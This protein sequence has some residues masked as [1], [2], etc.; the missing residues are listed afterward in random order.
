MNSMSWQELHFCSSFQVNLKA[1]LYFYQ[2]LFSFLGSFKVPHGGFKAFG[3]EI[4]KAY[5]DL[6][7]LPVAHTCFNSV[8][9]P[10]YPNKEILKDKLLKAILEGNLGFG[11]G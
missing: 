8:D 7:N 4:N 9:L 5:E 10:E 1:F 6:E 3:F 2:S 11:I